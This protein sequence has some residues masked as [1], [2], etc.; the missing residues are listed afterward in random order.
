MIVRYL[1]D[2]ELPPRR[3]SGMLAVVEQ[4]IAVGPLDWQRKVRTPTGSMPRRMRGGVRPKSGAMESVTENKPPTAQA[5]G[6]GE[7]AG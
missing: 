1:R 2:S 6:Q 3:F 5:E 7:K 4:T